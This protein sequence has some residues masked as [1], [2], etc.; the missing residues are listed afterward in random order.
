MS[1]TCQGG[2]ACSVGGQSTTDHCADKK[3]CLCVCVVVEDV[4]LREGGRVREQP[5]MVDC[6]KTC[7]C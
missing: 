7:H 6:T 2:F 4:C 5:I 1:L 3:T